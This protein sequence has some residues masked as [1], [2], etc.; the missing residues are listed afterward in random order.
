MC[1]I[2]GAPIGLSAESG[3]HEG[4]RKR[5]NDPLG[6]PR[7]ITTLVVGTATADDTGTVNNITEWQ[8]GN[9]RLAESVGSSLLVS[10][11]MRL[12]VSALGRFLHVDPIEAGVDNDD[13]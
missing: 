9:Q 7:Q 5:P 10:M 12:F 6:Q 11:G 8:Q 3:G 1:I 4:D 13:I 2:G